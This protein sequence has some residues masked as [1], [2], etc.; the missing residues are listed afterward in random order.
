MDEH[1]RPIEGYP[2]Y[3]VSRSGEIESSWTRHGRAV[4]LTETWLPLRPARR[5]WGHLTVNLSRDG[6]KTCRFVHRLVLEAF[7]GP[8]PAGLI[9]CHNDGDPSNNDVANLRWDTHKANSDDM[10]KHGRR[11]MGSQIN[12]K[13]IEGDVVEIRRLRAEGVRMGDLAAKYGVTKDNIA[14]IVY[15]RSWRHLP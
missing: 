15:R 1:F 4:V 11:K 7:V 14:A 3:R 2:G 12:A 5:R 8:C 10:L 6:K 13:L 9:C